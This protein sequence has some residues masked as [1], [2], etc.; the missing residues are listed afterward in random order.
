MI[1][2]ENLRKYQSEGFK[3]I[4]GWCSEQLFATIDL[5]ASASINKSGGCLEIGVHHGKFYI[6]LNQVI[7]STETS[8]AVDVFHNQHLNIDWSGSG[9]LEIFRSNLEKYD[10]HQGTN[11]KVII[12]DSTDY[13]LELEKRIGPGSLRLISID[14]G[15]S[16]EHTVNDLL[17]ANRLVKN[18]GVVILDDVMNYH[19]PGVMEGLSKFMST[20]PTLVPFAIG[21]NKLYLCKLSFQDFYFRYFSES[22]LMT[23]HVRF[24]G[25]NVAAL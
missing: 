2:N 16:V 17:L 15:H 10:A 18:E 4:E 20:S 9:S 21:E 11:T 1:S 22:P 12:G 8:Y 23:K 25:Y 19:W 3:L 13:G 14:G 7:P 5:L 24:F 6:L